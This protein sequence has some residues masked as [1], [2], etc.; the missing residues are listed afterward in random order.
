MIAST[1][2]LFYVGGLAVTSKFLLAATIGAVI[3]IIVYVVHGCGG[4]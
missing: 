1:D 3:A 2:T 4:I